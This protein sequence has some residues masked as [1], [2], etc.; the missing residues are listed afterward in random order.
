MI[1]TN[2]HGTTNIWQ[3]IMV[4][5]KVA[6]TPTSIYQLAQLAKITSPSIPM[7]SFYG[8]AFGAS[9][10]SA[11][12]ISVTDTSITISWTAYNS[13]F[14]N[15]VWSPNNSGVNNLAIA[16]SYTIQNLILASDYTITFKPFDEYDV[17][18]TELT[19]NGRTSGALSLGT[20]TITSTHN[21]I[22]VN[23]TKRKYA[24]VLLSWNDGAPIRLENTKIS[25]YNLTNQPHSTNYEFKIIPYNANNVPGT[26]V[27]ILGKTLSPP[28]VLDNAYISDIQTNS[29]KVVWTGSNIDTVRVG[30]SGNGE[31]L[32]VSGNSYTITGL[33]MD[34]YYEVSVTPFDQYKQQGA[35]ILL[36]DTTA[37]TLSV[38]TL[39]Y[40]KVDPSYFILYHTLFDYNYIIIH[41]NNGGQSGVIHSSAKMSQLHLRNMDPNTDYTFKV[42][43]YDFLNRP[44][45]EQFL[46]VPS[47]PMIYQARLERKQT[48]ITLFWD[49]R[50]YDYVDI[51]WN[52]GANRVTNIPGSSYTVSGL[53]VGVYYGFEIIPVVAANNFRGN[54]YYIGDSTIMYRETLGY[55]NGSMLPFREHQFYTSPDAWSGEIDVWIFPSIYPP[56]LTVPEKVRVTLTG[57]QGSA[58][59]PL[60]IQG[61]AYHTFDWMNSYNQQDNGWTK[62]LIEAEA[63]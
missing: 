9:I 38:G 16:S 28:P 21:S 63:F 35:V 5:Y 24:N 30:W 54:A 46:T 27:T 13:K 48:A 39:S 56:P 58:P 53:Q 32:D 3:D 44:K 29:M 55:G 51:S 6:K 34:T 14:V 41:W 1:I 59:D 25:T 7:S 50:N 52:D 36:G 4:E 26:T 11:K 12:I 23:W 60:I 33:G 37:G 57:A 45:R 61:P 47:V 31:A 49:G 22:T 2:K 20:T 17:A 8:K 15:L 62:M 43:L 40:A 19:I 10:S 18:G 42:V